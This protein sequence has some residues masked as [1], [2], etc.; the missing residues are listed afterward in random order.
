MATRLR[1]DSR[2]S[3]T[4]RV[5]MFLH[6]RRRA[7]RHCRIA[8]VLACYRRL[9]ISPL[10][11]TASAHET[12]MASR[13]QPRR[14]PRAG[15]RGRDWQGGNEY[16]SILYCVLFLRGGVNLF[17]F[18]FFFLG[19]AFA[20]FFSSFFSFLAGGAFIGCLFFSSFFLPP[21]HVI[22]VVGGWLGRGERGFVFKYMCESGRCESDGIYLE[23]HILYKKPKREV[24]RSHSI[25]VE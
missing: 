14:S 23:K 25:E 22:L 18:L 4:T 1:A 13:R 21:F 9:P 7:R 5:P 24:T 17:L 15:I 11:R 20:L 16:D 8:A 12:H 2:H 3:P 6:R 10:R 19:G